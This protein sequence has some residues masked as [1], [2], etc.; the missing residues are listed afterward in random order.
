[1]VAKQSRNFARI[2]RASVAIIAASVIGTR[3]FVPT[4]SRG[5]AIFVGPAVAVV[6]RMRAAASE[7]FVVRAGHAIVAIS[8]AATLAARA[9]TTLFRCAAQG[10]SRADTVGAALVDGARIGI[11][12]I[13]RSLT[14]DLVLAHT[15][16]RCTAG[17]AARA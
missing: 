2:V 11:I 14:G 6:R 12:A 4:I 15:S 10:R 8:P 9:V 17:T 1:M 3:F 13:F 7:A 5:R 16:G